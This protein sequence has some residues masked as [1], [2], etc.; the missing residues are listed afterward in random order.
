[1]PSYTRSPI[2]TGRVR[3]RLQP[4][5]DPKSKIEPLPVQEAITRLLVLFDTSARHGTVPTS[6][7]RVTDDGPC[8]HFKISAN[9]YC[10]FHENPALFANTGLSEGG[11]YNH[12]RVKAQLEALDPSCR[13]RNQAPAGP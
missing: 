2:I 8:R 1:M 12:P 6:C 10:E 5:S 4:K 9:L 3:G 11:F 13:G 7:K